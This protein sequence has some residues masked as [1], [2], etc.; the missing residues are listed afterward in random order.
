MGTDSGR[1]TPKDA[2]PNSGTATPISNQVFLANLSVD[3]VILAELTATGIDDETVQKV[4]AV[5]RKSASSRIPLATPPLNIQQ[6]QEVR[7]EMEKLNPT[8]PKTGNKDGP[9]AN[10]DKDTHID[11]DGSK[12]ASDAIV[13]VA[14]DVIVD[15]AQT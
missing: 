12:V 15:V 5:V 1:A 10:E 4:L 14:S 7:A 11:A 9:N 6:A 2:E 13:D 8:P 3:P